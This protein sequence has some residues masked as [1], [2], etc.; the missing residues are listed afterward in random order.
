MLT[1]KIA[2]FAREAT[3]IIKRARGQFV[4]A[5][6]IMGNTHALIVFAKGRSLMND[7]SAIFICHVVVAKDAE[8]SVFKLRQSD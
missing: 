2:D 5:N 3:S 7:T 1:G 8:G 4:R 6:H